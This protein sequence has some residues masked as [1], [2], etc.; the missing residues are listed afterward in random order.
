MV[1]AARLGGLEKLPDRPS[2]RDLWQDMVMILIIYVSFCQRNEKM[3]EA[4]MT[5]M[6][7]SDGEAPG[8]TM[9]VSCHGGW[10]GWA[11]RPG[12]C[13]SG[14]RRRSWRRCCWSPQRIRWRPSLSAGR[15]SWSSSWTSTRMAAGCLVV[16]LDVQ[17]DP[18]AF[19]V[20]HDI[21]R[22]LEERQEEE[23]IRHQQRI[24]E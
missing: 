8:A 12:T 9:A 13:W 1:E 3:M 21:G 7:V 5:C 16:D 11:G 20:L 15:S 23:Q 19:D 24:Q 22:K 14:T 4:K 10:S 2:G 18:F 17:V 6:R